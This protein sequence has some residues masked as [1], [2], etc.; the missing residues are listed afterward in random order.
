M[1]ILFKSLKNCRKA[2]QVNQ[3]Q[4]GKIMGLSQSYI[5]EIE[6]GRKLI[7]F[8]MAKQLL[9]GL[10]ESLEDDETFDERQD[11]VARIFGQW[12][13]ES[14]P[15][16]VALEWLSMI[17]RQLGLYLECPN[18]GRLQG[19]DFV[20]SVDIKALPFRKPR[21]ASFPF[22]VRVIPGCRSCLQKPYSKVVHHYCKW[23]SNGEI[24]A[25]IDTPLPTGFI[26]AE[27]SVETI[28]RHSRWTFYRTY[29][30]PYVVGR[31]SPS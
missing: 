1:N 6:T 17:N 31:N 28:K 2:A 10:L 16:Y 5:S 24:R 27:A 15:A 9:W 4:L 7:S 8:S 14:S 23:S 11:E 26:L 19:F 29:S 13:F 20:I 22:S 3:K 18:C 25:M 30:A 12:L 21:S